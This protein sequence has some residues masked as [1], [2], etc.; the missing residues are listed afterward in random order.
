M[1]SFSSHIL[2]M[3]FMHCRLGA[4]LTTS[5]ANACI[6]IH[7]ALPFHYPSEFHLHGSCGSIA[8][9]V[10][11]RSLHASIAHESEIYETSIW[12]VIPLMSVFTNHF[13]KR[14]KLS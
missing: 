10:T 3:Q 4:K 14:I 6:L 1:D 9:D 5:F 8:C 13:N 7:F 2:M 12:P 11:D